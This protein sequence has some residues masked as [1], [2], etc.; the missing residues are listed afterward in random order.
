[1][2]ITIGVSGDIGSFSEEAGLQ[3]AQKAALPHFQLL[4]LMDMEGVLSALEGGHIDLGVFPVVN[5]HGGLVTSA[6]EAMG[7][8]SF[9]LV[10]E[11]WLDVQ[12][13]LLTRPEIGITQI[14]QIVSHSQGLAQCRNY[15]KANFPK[16]KQI[17]WEDTAKA[18]RDLSEGKLEP[19]SAVIAPERCAQLYHLSIPAKAIQDDQPNLTAFI[20]TQPL[21]G[22]TSE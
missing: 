18:A 22:E 11:F 10:G 5:L 20:I 21:K 13:C 4:Y 9:Q 6:F 2:S 8:H 12:Q 19:T 7:R 3:Y 16:A 14:Q 17:A 15:L 1:M